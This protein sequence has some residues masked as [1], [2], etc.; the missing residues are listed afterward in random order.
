MGV[1]FGFDHPYHSTA[2]SEAVNRVS[3]SETEPRETRC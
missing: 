1:G 3:A 2:H